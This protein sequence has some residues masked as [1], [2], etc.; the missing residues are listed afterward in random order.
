MELVER[1]HRGRRAISL[2]GQR[3]LDTTAWECYLAELLVEAG[4]EPSKDAGF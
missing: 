3:G 1:I 4:R 2:A